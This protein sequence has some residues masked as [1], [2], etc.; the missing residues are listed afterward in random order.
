MRMSRLQKKI[1]INVYIKSAIGHAGYREHC[2]HII[3]SKF[4]FFFALVES[5]HQNSSYY[6]KGLNFFLFFLATDDSR[7]IETW[8]CWSAPVIANALSEDSC[9]SETGDANRPAIANTA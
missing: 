4:R 9:S 3:R 7:A 8:D 6:H 2:L 5:L 1:A